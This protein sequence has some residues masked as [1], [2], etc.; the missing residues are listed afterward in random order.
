MEPDGP[1]LAGLAWLLGA[2]YNEV[3]E[4]LKGVAKLHGEVLPSTNAWHRD[5]LEQMSG[6]TTARAALLSAPLRE[7]L[8]EFRAFRH[9]S[10][11]ATFLELDWPRME[12][13]FARLPRMLHAFFA[14][15][16]MFVESSA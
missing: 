3:E 7:Q 15:C 6:P 4:V 16:D 2:I 10:R 9:A 14:A 13:L 12:P 5:L 8:D 1:D 11:H